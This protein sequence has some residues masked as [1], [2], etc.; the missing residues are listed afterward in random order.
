MAQGV[1]ELAIQPDDLSLIPKTPHGEN[2][3]KR[4]LIH[5]G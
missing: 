5:T 3:G 1:K 4:K 2:G